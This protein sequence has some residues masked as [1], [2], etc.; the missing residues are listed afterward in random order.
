VRIEC[1][2]PPLVLGRAL[3]SS[4]ETGSGEADLVALGRGNLERGGDGG[5]EVIEAWARWRSARAYG[6]FGIEP[7]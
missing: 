7:E 3:S 6:R 5:P 2:C 4:P 1:G